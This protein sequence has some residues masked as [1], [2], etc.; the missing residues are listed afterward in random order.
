MRNDFDNLGE[1]WKWKLFYPFKYF[2]PNIRTYEV[3][4][5]KFGLYIYWGILKLNKKV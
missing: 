3:I 5:F 1:K 2:F 4:V